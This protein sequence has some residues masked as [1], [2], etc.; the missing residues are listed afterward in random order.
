[1]DT[2]ISDIE[3]LDSVVAPLQQQFDHLTRAHGMFQND[4]RLR[5]V[6]VSDPLEDGSID[7]TFYGVV[8]KFRLLFTY[9]VS[10][11]P[12]GRVLVLHCHCTFGKAVQTLIG[13]FTLN[14][15]GYTNL[16]PNGAGDVPNLAQEPG[17]IVLTF[18]RKALA[19][20]ASIAG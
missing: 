20:N 4:G 15:R 16:P 3:R 9:T 12:L 5:A 13:E 17:F 7:V 8:V 2:L 11:E 10:G 18:L 1:M 14:E 19:A 6:S